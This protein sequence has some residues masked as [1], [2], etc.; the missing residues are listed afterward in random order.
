MMVSLTISSEFSPPER[1]A[2]DN[3]MKEIG[4]RENRKRA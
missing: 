2:Y 3:I 4:L 1:K